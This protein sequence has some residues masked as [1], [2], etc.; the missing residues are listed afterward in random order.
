MG[1]E[2]GLHRGR[3][4]P[5]L[6][7]PGRAAAPRAQGRWAAPAGGRTATAGYRALSRSAA[8]A[9]RH[10]GAT[11]RAGARTGLGGRAARD[12]WGER[13]GL[14]REERRKKE[15]GSN[16]WRRLTGEEDPHRSREKICRLP[17]IRGSN[18]RTECAA[19]K[20]STR[21]RQ[22]YPRIPQTMQGSGVIARR[23]CR[24][25]WNRPELRRAIPGARNRIWR[26]CFVFWNGLDEM[27]PDMHIYLGFGRDKN[28]VKIRILPFL[29][30]GKAYKSIFCA[31]NII[32]AFRNSR[33]IPIN[34]LAP[35]E[36]KNIIRISKNILSSSNK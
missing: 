24:R 19:T 16:P 20:P 6:Q 17:E 35:N 11:G 9:G 31:Q 10:R 1:K 18:R 25:S 36:L 28:S 7:V 3:A 5:P 15:L 8:T 26:K 27:K 14:R 13:E 29:K 4:R 21:R 2:Q 34:V 23:S 30:F 32:Y 12:R 22:R 33:K